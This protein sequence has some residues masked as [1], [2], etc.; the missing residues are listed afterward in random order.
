ML[1]DADEPGSGTVFDWALADAV[2][3]GVRLLLAGGLH[4]EQ[5]RDRRSGGYGRGASTCRRGVETTPGS[6]RKD[7]R[8]LRSF[9]DEARHAGGETF[10]DDGWAPDPEAAPYDWMADGP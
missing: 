2:P 9:V 6:G 7:A 5:R 1:V 8:K 3:P 4:A 10:D